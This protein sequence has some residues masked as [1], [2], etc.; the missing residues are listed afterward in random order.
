M[1]TLGCD[2]E[3]AVELSLQEDY[4]GHALGNLKQMVQ[5]ILSHFDEDASTFYLTGSGN[6]RE[7]I[8]TIAPY[9]GNRDSLHKP[10]YYKELRSY[11]TQQWG[12]Q[13]VDGME[14]DD[15]VSI[16]QYK[17]PDKST[18]IV[19]GDKD[20][21]NTPGWNYNPRKQEMEYITLA[22]ANL[23]FWSQVATGDPVDNIK[24]LYKVGPKT[25]EKALAECG[26]DLEKFK[27]WVRRMYDRQYKDEGPHA[28]W[29]NATL[30]WMM[31]KPWINWDGSRLDGQQE[32]S[33]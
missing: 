15:A 16:E 26:G 22:E 19:S 11:L 18:C 27:D 32:E 20:L 8:A 33:S 13:V 14:A 5:E 4:L 7:H 9:K 24:G 1:E 2:K 12:A 28:L 10:R 23:N 30:L 3:K 6:Y 17:H 31:R 21:R 29:E 25:V